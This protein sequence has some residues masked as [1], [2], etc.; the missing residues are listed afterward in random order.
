MQDLYELSFSSPHRQ[1]IPS[2]ATVSG[3][4]FRGQVVSDHEMY[5]CHGAA[6]RAKHWSEMQKNSLP[7]FAY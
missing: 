6:V 3:T 4:R 1:L 5:Q 2:I 7:L